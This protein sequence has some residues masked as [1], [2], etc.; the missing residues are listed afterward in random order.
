VIVHYL[1]TFKVS[2]PWVCALGHDNVSYAAAC[3]TKKVL[4]R[5]YVRNA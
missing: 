1:R 2:R 3:A 5:A 4:L